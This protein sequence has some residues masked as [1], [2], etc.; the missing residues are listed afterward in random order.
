MDFNLYTENNPPTN[1][2]NS[3]SVMGDPA[4]TSAGSPDWNYSIQSASD[5][6]ENGDP[7]LKI[8]YD[9][10]WDPRNTSDPSIGAYE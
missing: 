7:D 6:K 4:F 2:M 10:N 3:N 1:T 9:I 5:A 8:R